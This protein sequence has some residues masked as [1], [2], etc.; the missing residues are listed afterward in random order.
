[1]Q[2]LVK[3][4]LTALCALPQAAVAA[5]VVTYHN[6]NSR[7][8]AYIEPTLT[9]AAAA[10]VKLDTGFNATVNGHVYA[11]P[12]F[13]HAKGLAPEVIVV[14][15]SNQVAALNAA[16]GAPIWTVQLPAPVPSN[17]LGC[18]NV[19]PEGIHGTPVIDASTGTLYLDALVEIAGAPTHTLYGLSLQTGATLPGWPLNVDAALKAA[20][21]SFTAH[22]QGER[23][24]AL[25]HGGHLYVVYG[26]RYGDCD[27]YYGTAIEVDPTT[28]KLVGHWQTRASGGGIW[29]QGGISSDGKS[30][31]VTTGNTMNASTWMDGEA[32][33]RLRHGLAHSTSTADYFTPSNWLNLDQTDEDLGGTEAIPLDIHA[34]GKTFGRI[35]AFGKNGSAY[36]VNRN[37]LGGIGGQ[38]AT[39]SLSGTVIITAPAVYETDTG[40]MVAFTNYA[41]NAPCSG[42]AMDMIK[43]D[44]RGS[45]PISNVWC[46][47]FNGGGSPIITTT[48]GT[49]NPV[50]WVL[51]AGGDNVLHGFNA[52][53]GAVLY[54]GTNV[55]SG[56]HNFQ[57]L[58]AAEGRFYVAGD[59]K[60]YAFSW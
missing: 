6:S 4:A 12:L 22:N 21:A 49:K 45:K 35:I 56:L 48:D 18:G 33:L 60:V 50:V 10:G 25:I 2:L 59:G 29:A 20:G 55:L 11:Q 40:T 52:T 16:T 47:A 43:V 26:G 39:Q 44:A 41:A 3:A 57:T 1:M 54:T 9:H 23:S 24:G 5:S 19:N 27:P 51:G 14:T 37:N 36:L 42:N 31:F 32:I 7:Q 15:E 34:G 46:A 58:I 30:L 53:T 13:W 38:I 28:Q 17:A 8:G